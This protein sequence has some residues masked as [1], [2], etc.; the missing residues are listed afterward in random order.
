[1]D[2]GSGCATT[3]ALVGSVAPFQ[4]AGRDTFHDVG[5]T[6]R[7]VDD[8]TLV[9]EDFTFDGGGIDIRIYA[10]AGG[11]F[12]P[13]TGFPISDDLFG[14]RFTGE[15]LWLTLPAGR[16]LDDLDGVSVWCVDVGV[17][18]GSARF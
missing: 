13:P 3:H 18:F 5:G 17:D 4:L 7:V 8:C 15:S 1:M 6:A 12:T 2:S 9:L 10:G 11:V 16:T 14:M